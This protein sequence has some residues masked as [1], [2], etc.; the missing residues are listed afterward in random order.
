MTDQTINR[1]TIGGAIFAGLALTAIVYLTYYKSPTPPSIDPRKVELLQVTKDSLNAANVLK[2]THIATVKQ[3]EEM[4]KVKMVTDKKFGGFAK[5][6]MSQG[7]S[8]QGVVLGTLAR[9]MQV[10]CEVSDGNY[11]LTFEHNNNQVVF[12]TTI[13]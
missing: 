9:A 6:R 2:T 3:A 12:Q 10:E 11:S 8:L 13:L 1:L 7:D 4:P 5:V